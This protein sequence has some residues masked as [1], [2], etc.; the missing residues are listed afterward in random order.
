MP[1]Y[2]LVIPVYFNEGCLLPLMASLYSDV[3][4]KNPRLTCQIIFVDD[5]SGDG[6]LEEL[7]E[8]REKYDQVE[9]VKFTR[10]FGQVNALIAG[11]SR[12]QGKCVVAMSADGQ[13][14][15]AIINDMLK[16]YYEEGYEVVIC[17]REGRDE[18]FYRVATS[19]IFYQLI[20]KLVFP[21]MPESG[22]DFVLFGERALKTY[23]K[24]VDAN[25]FYQGGILWMGY[26]TKFIKYFRRQRLAGKSRWTFGK[27]LTFLL[28]GVLS[29]SFF[30]IRL[31]SFIGLLIAVLGFAYAFDI[32]IEKIF[33]GNEVTGWAP[34]MIISLVIGGS[35]LLM[36]GMIGEYLWRT[37]S[38]V[39]NREFYVVDNIYEP[40]A[41][42]ARRKAK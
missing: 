11:F 39:R 10:N 40:K 8:I 24:N 13:D 36:L 19:R 1:D 17:T 7:L 25:P 29:Y 12:A 37:L 4:S 18:S 26:K 16:A 28:D 33:W 6:S 23:L 15:P 5:G 32:F 22:F 38:Q 20:K 31:L 27:K 41:R 9:I 2:S 30:P 21:N 3:I 42:K 35:Q 14:P 34:I